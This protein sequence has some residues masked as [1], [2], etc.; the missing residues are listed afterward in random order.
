MRYV[1]SRARTPLG[2]KKLQCPCAWPSQY[3]T[4]IANRLRPKCHATVGPCGTPS[5]R[6][7][8]WPSLTPWIDGNASMRGATSFR[9]RPAGQ[10]IPCGIGTAGASAWASTAATSAAAA[11][12]AALRTTVDCRDSRGHVETGTIRQG[13]GLQRRVRLRTGVHGATRA[14]S[15]SCARMSLSHRGV[16]TE[17]KENACASLSCRPH[18]SRTQADESRPSAVGSSVMR[19]F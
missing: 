17:R 16:D 11:M 14:I 4:T 6:R 10:M 5:D 18:T 1:P 9:V 8:C 2:Q 12:P 7:Q 13:A 15:V 3:D 19:R